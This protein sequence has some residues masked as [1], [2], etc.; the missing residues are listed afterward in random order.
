M[1]PGRDLA[2]T[3]VWI[4]F[5]TVLSTISISKAKD[6]HGREIT[7]EIAFDVALNA[8]VVLLARDWIIYL[9]IF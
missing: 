2:D 7:P 8:Y 1:C 3:S 9:F 5:A 4:V 6:E